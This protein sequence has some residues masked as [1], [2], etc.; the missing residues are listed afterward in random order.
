MQA[1][2]ENKALLAKKAP[3]T[4]LGFAGA[5]RRRQCASNCC[6]N[7]VKHV[8]WCYFAFFVIVVGSSSSWG[9]RRRAT[10]VE[11]WT[12][13]WRHR[14]WGSP[15]RQCA[16]FF[17]LLY[18]YSRVCSSRLVDPVAGTPRCFESFLCVKGGIG[19]VDS[20]AATGDT[21]MATV[22]SAG[23]GSGA[24]ASS[25]A[26]SK[27]PKRFEIKKWN[28]VALWA[29]GKRAF[30]Y[31]RM[32]IFFDWALSENNRRLCGFW[33]SCFDEYGD[34]RAH[35]SDFQKELYGVNCTS[36]SRPLPDPLAR[37]HR[38]Q[39]LL[40]CRK[41]LVFNQLGNVLGCRVSSYSSEISD[42]SFVKIPFADIV[43]DNCAICRNH[44]MDLC[45]ECQ[46]NQASATSEECTV[47]WGEIFWTLFDLATLTVFGQILFVCFQFAAMADGSSHLWVLD[48][49]FAITPFTSIASA[50]GW[51][52]GK[53]A[54]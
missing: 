10:D 8:W 4:E 20:M 27:R 54:H 29:W 41:F 49:V 52:R 44:I 32:L 7:L 17:L 31:G 5:R 21:E 40:L 39:H 16:R 48:Q 3:E 19:W 14:A 30:L 33:K 47:A 53:C 50:D 24:G 25:S 42:R 11:I 38:L 28:A 46:A 26:V 23:E 2:L 1:D 13:E 36:V 43:V 34:R 9:R 37:N 15:Y 35:S 22:G 45:I 12:K 6:F 51:R 18:F